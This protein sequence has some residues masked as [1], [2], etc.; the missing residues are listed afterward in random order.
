[1]SLAE[2][3]TESQEERNKAAEELMPRLA[4][5]GERERAANLS[6][7]GQ[8]FT[9]RNSGKVSHAALVSCATSSAN[10]LTHTRTRTHTH[11]RCAGVLLIF[12]TVMALH[13]SIIFLPDFANE[14]LP[15]VVTS[16]LCLFSPGDGVCVCVVCVCVCVWS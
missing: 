3:L 16:Y 1:M 14:Y 5:M 12:L 13:C 7:S 15:E 4:E 2:A 11:K 10:S 9:C 8:L 6:F